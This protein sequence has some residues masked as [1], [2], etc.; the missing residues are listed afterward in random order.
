M[1]IRL[2]DIV[3]Q[4]E[5]LRDATQLMNLSN[6]IMGVAPLYLKP[7]D[8]SVGWEARSNLVKQLR[9]ANP[10]KTD[11][12]QQEKHLYLTTKYMVKYYREAGKYY[13]TV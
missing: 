2:V 13:K 3:I 1:M 8:G 10:Q 11:A 12:E 4:E 9:E 6:R 5:E 7:Y